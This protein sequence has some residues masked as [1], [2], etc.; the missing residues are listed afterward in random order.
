MNVVR[1][2]NGYT[3]TVHDEDGQTTVLG[4]VRTAVG[5][6]VDAS[7]T[8]N[9]LVLRVWTEQRVVAVDGLTEHLTR[10]A[11]DAAESG[12]FKDGAYTW[13]RTAPGVTEVH[14]SHP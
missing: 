6:S 12:W 11:F 5:T 10:A 2:R 4:A 1:R 9:G 8:P 14:L 7:R 13:V 3:S